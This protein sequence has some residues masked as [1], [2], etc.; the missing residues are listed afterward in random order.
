M[1]QSRE[2]VIE[3]LKETFTKADLDINQ[4]YLTCNSK[5]HTSE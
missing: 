2:K 5:D 1:S 3:G 4:V